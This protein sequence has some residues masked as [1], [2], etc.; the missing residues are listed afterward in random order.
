MVPEEGSKAVRLTFFDK[1]TDDS[2]RS[3]TK[4]YQSP[5]FPDSWYEKAED[6]SQDEVTPADAI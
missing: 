4:T 2:V 5:I 3:T 1:Q 6:D